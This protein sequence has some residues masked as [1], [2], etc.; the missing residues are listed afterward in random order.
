MLVKG[1]SEHHWTCWWKHGY[2]LRFQKASRGLSYEPLSRHAKLWVAHASGMPGTFSPPPTSKE[3]ASWW[4]RH[5]SRHERHARAAMH[6]GIANP[7]WSGKRSWHSW[8][9]CIPQFYVS[10]KR[11]MACHSTILPTGQWGDVS[12][13]HSIVHYLW[14]RVDIYTGIRPQCLHMWRLLHR[15]RN[16][17]H[18]H[19]V[20]SEFR[21]ILMKYALLWIYV[22]STL[23]SHRLSL[24]T[25]Y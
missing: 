10:G 22:F 3:T 15:V 23:I 5:A 17:T 4:S 9:I 21:W 1:A 2:K 16:C 18:S 24:N 12:A 19:C 14:I 6:V 25:F 11:P 20:H 7:Q 13:A 8:R